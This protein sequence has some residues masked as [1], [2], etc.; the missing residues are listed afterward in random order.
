VESIRESISILTIV[1]D[2][3]GGLKIRTIEEFTDSKAHAESMAA[4]AAMAK[5]MPTK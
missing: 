5:A 3:D 4:I 2:D 1:T